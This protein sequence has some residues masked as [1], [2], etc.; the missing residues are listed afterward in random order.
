[1]R[2]VFAIH[3]V[4]VNVMKLLPVMRSAPAIL[5]VLAVGARVKVLRRLAEKV[6]MMDS[7]SFLR[8]CF[9]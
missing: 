7:C 3:N 9:S 4:L 2:T 5:N 1:M 6:A 8:L